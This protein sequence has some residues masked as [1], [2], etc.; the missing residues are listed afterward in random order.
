M[1]LAADVISKT[2]VK[3]EAG[4]IAMNKRVAQDVRATMKARGATMPE[5]LPIEPPILEIKKRLKQRAK[6]GKLSDPST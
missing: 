2:G 4:A 6:Q 1:E 5:N 3:G